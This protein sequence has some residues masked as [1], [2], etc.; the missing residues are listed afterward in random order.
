MI[1]IM[2]STVITKFE[3]KTIDKNEGFDYICY[4]ILQFFSQTPPYS[5]H[6]VLDVE[7]QRLSIEQRIFVD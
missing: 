2:Y 1:I 7:R 5:Y 3:C 6:F 4:N